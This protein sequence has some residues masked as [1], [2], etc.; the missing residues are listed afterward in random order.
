VAKVRVSHEKYFELVKENI[1]LH[2]RIKNMKHNFHYTIE[3]S[4]A[5]NRKMDEKYTKLN[6]D[7][8]DLERENYKLRDLLKDLL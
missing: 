5:V 3:K 4:E 6:K 1:C 2:E 7:Y 8:A